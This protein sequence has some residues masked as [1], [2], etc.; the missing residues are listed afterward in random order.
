MRQLDYRIYPSLL[1][2]YQKFLDAPIEVEDFSNVTEDGEYKRTEDEIRKG[3]ELKLINM[4]NRC[5][6]VPI[7]AADKGTAFNEII[8]CI[9][10]HRKPREDMVIETQ[11]NCEKGAKDLYGNSIERKPIAIRAQYN[12]FSF[13]FDVDLCKELAEYYKGSLPQYLAKADIETMYGNVELY[14]YIDEWVRDKVYDIKTTSRYDFGKF[15]RSWQK[16][17]Y[18]Y[19]LVKSGLIDQ[20]TSF[21]YTV[22]LLSK[23]SS[24]TPVIS[25]KIYPEVYNFNYLLSE[26]NIRQMVERFIAWLEYRREYITDKKIFGGEN[27]ENYVGVE[28]TD[29]D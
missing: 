15:S 5:P 24:R 17:V 13:L 25:G 4:I 19:C 9:I 2:T 11:Y 8:D 27:E 28:L 6:K 1:D 29:I 10:E 20:I 12:G 16:E 22:V 14:G 26:R 3:Y 7:E 21:E 23:P 18:P